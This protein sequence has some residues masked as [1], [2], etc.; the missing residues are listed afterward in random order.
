MRVGVDQL[1]WQRVRLDPP[2]LDTVQQMSQ[3]AAALRR[4]ELLG[5]VDLDP[6][7]QDVDTDEG[8]PQ[9]CS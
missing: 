6:F 5:G 9:V 2:F 4:Q 1:G 7:A 8:G 3:L